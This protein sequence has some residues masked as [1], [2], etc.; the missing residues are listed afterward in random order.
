MWG[1]IGLG[2]AILAIAWLQWAAHHA[3]IDTDRNLDERE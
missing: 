1:W 3:P 2:V